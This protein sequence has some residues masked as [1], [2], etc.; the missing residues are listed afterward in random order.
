MCLKD[1]ERVDVVSLPE[2]CAMY[3]ADGFC[4]VAHGIPR[5]RLAACYA[6]MNRLL[7]L[8]SVAGQARTPTSKSI[9]VMLMASL[10]EHTT[11]EARCRENQVAVLTAGQVARTGLSVRYAW[12]SQILI[13]HREKRGLRRNFPK[14]L[15]NSDPVS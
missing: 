10:T 9:P 14:F 15:E 5:D 7:P 13:M 8:S 2:D 1:S 12:D 4:L 3:R 6:E 11:T